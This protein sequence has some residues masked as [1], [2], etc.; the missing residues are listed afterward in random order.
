MQSRWF[1]AS[2]GAV[3]VMTT[4]IVVWW[5][6]GDQSSTTLN[7]DYIV[8]PP[9]ISTT[10]ELAPGL[11]STVLLVASLTVLVI[12][13]RR[14]QLDPRW[15]SI[16]LMLMGSGAIVG[17]AVRVVTAGVVGANIGGGIVILFGGPFVAV[18]IGWA[19]VSAASLVRRRRADPQGG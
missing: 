19:G 2:A 11:V 16:V 1:G 3:A 13:T 8:K 14:R 18:L 10:S 7:P 9:T 4:P 5:I 12:A 17:L 6:V 15:W